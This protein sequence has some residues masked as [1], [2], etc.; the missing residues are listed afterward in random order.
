[1]NYPRVI[2]ALARN[3]GRM[4]GRD[5]FLT[6]LVLYIIAIAAVLHFGLPALETMIIEAGWGWSL[7][8]YYP[9]LVTFMT[10]FEGPMLA[11]TIIGFMLLED[12]DQHTLPALMVTPLSLRSYL[13]YRMAIATLAAFVLIL[14]IFWLLGVAL[15]PAPQLLLVAA[16]G[17]L[18]GPIMGLTLAAFAE[19]KVQGF[20]MLKIINVFG[21]ALLAAW[22]VVEPLQYLF[23]II[24]L[25]W[26]FKAYWLALAGSGTWFFWLI[27]G[28]LGSLALLAW[29][30]QRFQRAVTSAR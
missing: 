14:A 8:D 5:S 11:G 10:L 13:I 23:G 3:D 12:R 30:M 29:L 9:V 18:S 17:A 19:N 4:V 7:A 2:T 15:I 27:P 6:G 16:I 28:L 25:Y 1:M 24:P 21:L 26:V 22:F 20:A